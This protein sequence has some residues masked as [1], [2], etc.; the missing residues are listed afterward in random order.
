MDVVGFFVLLIV[1]LLKQCSSY[2]IDNNVEKI[3]LF[4]NYHLGSIG[5]VEIKLRR[6]FNQAYVT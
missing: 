3:L 2:L 5:I 4:D 1:V 6:T